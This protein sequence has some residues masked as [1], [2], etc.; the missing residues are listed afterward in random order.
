MTHKHTPAPWRIDEC[1]C[2]QENCKDF[3]VN[4]WFCQGGMVKK[5]DA[6]LIAA[7]PELLEALETVLLAHKYDG[8]MTTGSA[9]LSPAIEKMIEAKIAKAKGLE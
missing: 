1:P 7:A 5:A 8:A 9:A 6:R 3:N 4:G 2:G